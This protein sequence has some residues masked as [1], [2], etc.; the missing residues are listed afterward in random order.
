MSE[1]DV[2]DVGAVI[3]LEK[4]LDLDNAVSEIDLESIQIG[5]DDDAGDNGEEDNDDEDDDDDEEDSAQVERVH[6]KQDD[7]TDEDDESDEDEDDDT[8][9]PV[10]ILGCNSTHFDLLIVAEEVI[11][12]YRNDAFI[13][14]DSCEEDDD[15]DEGKCFS[16]E[17]LT[18][19][20]IGGSRR[21]MLRRSL[22]RQDIDE[23]DEDEIED[24]VD[25]YEELFI[26]LSEEFDITV[27]EEF[28]LE[29]GDLFITQFDECCA[30]VD[31]NTTVV[32]QCDLNG[33]LITAFAFEGGSIIIPYVLGGIAALIVIV[34][35]IAM[36]LYNK[37]SN[38][39]SEKKAEVAITDAQVVSDSK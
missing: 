2:C 14:D 37:K 32:G 18:P 36:T 5:G 39:E 25:G 12:T 10:F 34:V 26:E 20:E 33:F 7:D 35:L 28:Y 15:E 17:C 31:E 30:L 11:A 3:V 4:A 19:P 27:N 21:L 16:V 29:F 22:K 38:G 9:D 1:I 6:N 23:L 13:L 8:D 24:R